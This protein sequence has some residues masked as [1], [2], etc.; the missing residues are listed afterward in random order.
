MKRDTSNNQSF[1]LPL[2]TMVKEVRLN[3]SLPTPRLRLSQHKIGSSMANITWDFEMASLEIVA[4]ITRRIDVLGGHPM[5]LQ[6][7]AL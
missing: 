3:S 6:G 4:N 1:G 5:A 2:N 7:V